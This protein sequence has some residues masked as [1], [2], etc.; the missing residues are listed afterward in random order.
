[1][2]GR[3]LGK[4]LAPFGL[5]KKYKMPSTI[6]VSRFKAMEITQKTIKKI[7]KVSAELFDQSV[8]IEFLNE[9][10]YNL[11]A[12]MCGLAHE[13]MTLEGKAETDQK[14]TFLRKLSLPLNLSDHMRCYDEKEAT[15]HPYK[16]E[17]DDFEKLIDTCKRLGLTFTVTGESEYF[18]GHSFRLIIKKG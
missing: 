9:L 7:D 15:F 2:S 5:D 18:P 10:Y 16:G 13:K 14:P 12:I 4:W 11:G 3:G 6:A 1:L 8:K 17:M